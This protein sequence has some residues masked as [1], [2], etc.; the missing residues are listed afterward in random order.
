MIKLAAIGGG[1]G[2]SVLL[3]GLKKKFEVSAIVTVGDNGGGSG[4]LRED[5]NMLPCL[6]YTS[7]AADDLLTV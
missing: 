7:D 3:N 5:L 2:L 6:L 4:I 1:T